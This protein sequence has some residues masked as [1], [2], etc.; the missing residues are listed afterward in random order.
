V[1][2][3]G[4]LQPRHVASG[5]WMKRRGERYGNRGNRQIYV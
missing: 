3:A 2:A 1:T 5:R 4:V